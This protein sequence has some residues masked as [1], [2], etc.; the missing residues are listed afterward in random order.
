MIDRDV[1]TLC[2]A[3]RKGD[4]AALTGALTSIY[5]VRRLKVLNSARVLKYDQEKEEPD[6]PGQTCPSP[7]LTA[8][9][10]VRLLPCITRC[11]I[12]CLLI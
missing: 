7:L 6:L 12:E 5:S 10:A 2:D 3:I 4:P 1:T 8:V 9:I 11:S